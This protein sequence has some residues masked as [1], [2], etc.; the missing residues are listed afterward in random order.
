MR[1]I[2]ST[3]TISTDPSHTGATMTLG[4]VLRVTRGGHYVTTLAPKAGFYPEVSDV[5][6][7]AVTSLINGQGVSLVALNSSLRRDLWAAVN[8]SGAT[9]PEQPLVTKADSLVPTNLP[10]NDQVLVAYRLL[11]AIEAHYVHY[12]PELQF[13]LL[14]SP[15]VTWI[16][17]GG[18]IV[19][20]GGLVAIWPPPAAMRG[21][22]RAR[23]LA[24]IAQELGR[25]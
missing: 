4:A 10:G 7:Q 22:V 1:Y 16:W 13:T 3:G 17:L 12:P 20:L 14:A 9:L 6:G 5:P 8:F 19:L 25:A 24:R 23:Y 21:R 15:L 2:R 18:L 11:G